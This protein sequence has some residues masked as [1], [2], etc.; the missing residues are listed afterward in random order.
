MITRRKWCILKNL[1]FKQYLK[2]ALF[3]ALLCLLGSSCKSPDPVTLSTRQQKY[4]L[5]HAKPAS[6]M[7]IGLQIENGRA[8]W[9]NICLA[10]ENMTVR[11]PFASKYRHYS[12]FPI[13]RLHVNGKATYAIVDT[14]ATTSITEYRLAQ[15]ARITP[16]ISS[17]TMRMDDPTQLPSLISVGTM[18]PGGMAEIFLGIS[19]VTSISALNV[20]N[21][22]FAILNDTRGLGAVSWVDGYRIETILGNDFLSAFKYVTFDYPR[23]QM[24]FST[25]RRYIPETRKLVA[26]IPLQDSSPALTTVARLDQGRLFHAAFDTGGTFGLWLSSGMAKKL[27][28]SPHRITGGMEQGSSL[29]GS[30]TTQNIGNHTVTLGHTEIPGIPT[31]I[32]QTDHTGQNPAIAL[33]GN[34]LLHKFRVTID[35]TSNT[36]Y[37]ENP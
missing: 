4:L 30:T 32:S 34:N 18:T 23:E 25:E 17:Y 6:Q 31:V 11:V 9:E 13:I 20:A 29:V 36:V 14:G 8:F 35:Y 19:S 33:I 37:L 2:F 7:D 1:N 22:P 3:T 5:A 21:T 15:R 10:D 28:L 27:R 26:A 12:Q 16:L 24:T